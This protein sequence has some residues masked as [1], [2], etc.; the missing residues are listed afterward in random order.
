MGEALTSQEVVCLEAHCVLGFICSLT[1]I[2]R[3]SFLKDDT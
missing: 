2:F 3:A 1:G